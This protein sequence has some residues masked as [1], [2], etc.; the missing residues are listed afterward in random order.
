MFPRRQPG[1]PGAGEWA[2][3]RSDFSNIACSPAVEARALGTPDVMFA[4]EFS[5]LRFGGGTIAHLKLR[6]NESAADR[7]S[8][9]RVKLTRR[10]GF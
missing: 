8:C 7:A 1:S 9:A 2:D 6:S 3:C 5:A 4:R 10:R